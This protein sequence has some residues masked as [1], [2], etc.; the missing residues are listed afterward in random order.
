MSVYLV[1]ILTS[2]DILSIIDSQQTN[3][4]TVDQFI[5]GRAHN[6]ISEAAKLCI[7]ALRDSADAFP[8]LKS[9]LG[10]ISFFIDNHEVCPLLLIV[11]LY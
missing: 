4:D 5:P 1:R 3:G 11:L 7:R 10:G 8:P 9:L 2:V 6:V